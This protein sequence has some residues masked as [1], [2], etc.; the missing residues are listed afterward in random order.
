MKNTSQTKGKEAMKTT[1]NQFC[2]HAYILQRA[3][4]ALAEMLIADLDDPRVLWAFGLDEFNYVGL[5]A[6]GYWNVV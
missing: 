1:N 6:L 4:M 5:S 3:N 2:I